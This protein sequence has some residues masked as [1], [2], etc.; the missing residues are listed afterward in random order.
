MVT[1]YPKN[2]KATKADKKR[3]QRK[4][5]KK[6]QTNGII[7]GDQKMVRKNFD[8]KRE[9]IKK[10]VIKKGNREIRDEK[11]RHIKWDK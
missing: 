3:Q 8:K 2:E 6:C 11:R 5:T 7:K 1:K 4:T 10:N 9:K